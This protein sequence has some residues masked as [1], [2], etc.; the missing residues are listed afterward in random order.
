[1]LSVKNFRRQTIAFFCLSLPGLYSRLPI[2]AYEL[3][4]TSFCRVKY[5]ERPLV[6]QEDFRQKGRMPGQLVGKDV[7]DCGDCNEK[8]GCFQVARTFRCAKPAGLKTSNTLKK[9]FPSRPSDALKKRI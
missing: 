8:Q 2:N 1:M 9:R 7:G 3:I 4:S 6:S 5:I